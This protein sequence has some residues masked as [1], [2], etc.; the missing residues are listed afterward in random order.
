MKFVKFTAVAL[1]AALLSVGCAGEDITLGGSNSNATISN[2]G[3]LSI[4]SLVIDCRIDES[5][6]DT[7]IEPTQ[8]AP[9]TR[10]AVDVGTFN[11]SIINEANEVVASFKFSERP[12][13][14]IEL[15]TGDYIFKIQSGEVPGAAWESPVYGAS[16][17]FKIVRNEVTTLSE[18]VCSLMQVM[19]TITY[20]PDL[21]ERLGEKTITT[22]IVANNSLEYSLTESR[23]GYF[24]APQVNNTIELHISGT[25]AADKENFKVVEM[26]KEIRDVKAG[27]HSKIHIYIDHAAEGNLK[28]G[29]TLR[30]WVTDEIIPCNVADVVT[31]EE[32][33]EN[34]DNEGEETPV[35]D[36]NIVWDG[37]DISKREQIV[38]GIEVDL[39]ITA[40]KG[41]KGLLCE[42]DSGSLTPDV[43]AGVNLCNVLNLCYPDKSYDS[44]DPENFIDTEEKLRN[45]KFAVGEDVINKTFVKLSITE[46]MSILKGVSGAE[47]KHHNFVLTV[48]DNEDNTT[49]KTLMLQTGK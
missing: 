21:L 12:T 39:L 9:A 32:W 48:T 3:H 30:D 37:H 13:E 43:L 1:F 4:S 35:E 20:A 28:I 15:E 18:I 33:K 6:P 10:T 11:C 23:A 34:T 29:A 19:V 40:S 8:P 38:D 44:R 36:P 25:Y 7:G 47:L 5:T 31:E 14:N 41:I 27:Q 17:A 16:K 46:F 45:L 22:A 26:N 2:K 49:V 42:I 24:F